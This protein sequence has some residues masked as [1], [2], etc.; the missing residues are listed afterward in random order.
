MGITIGY[1]G[2]AKNEKAMHK[3]L[4]RADSFAHAHQWT[5]T[6][7]KDADNFGIKILAH[8]LV[9]PLFL[10]F[11]KDLQLN[12]YTKTQFGGVKIHVELIKLLEKIQPHFASLEISDEGEYYH[13]DLIGLAAVTA[14]DEPLGRVTA[15]HNFGAGDIIEIA[16]ITASA[17]PPKKAW[18]WT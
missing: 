10:V 14:A 17:T 16:I 11:N 4:A 13:A 12:N 7:V 3:I 9:E 8:P 18:R 2:V 15:I 1:K 5:L 6:V